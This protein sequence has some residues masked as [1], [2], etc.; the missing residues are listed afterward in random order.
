[1]F[2]KKFYL[3]SLVI[4]FRKTG[5]VTGLEFI[6][7][8]NLGHIFFP[9]ERPACFLYNFYTFEETMKSLKIS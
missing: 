8:P 5:K 1:M 4:H 9:F 3:C 2:K 6:N 7:L